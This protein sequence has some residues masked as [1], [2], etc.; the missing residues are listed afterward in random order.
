[1]SDLCLLA[2][3]LLNQGQLPGKSISPMPLSL[4]AAAIA[5]SPNCQP[6]L[7]KGTPPSAESTQPEFSRSSAAQSLTQSYSPLRLLPEITLPSPYPYPIPIAPE[8]S[9]RLLE[10]TPQV[11]QIA[12]QTQ[13]IRLPRPSSGSQLYQQRLA[14]LSA[15]RTYTRL[16]VDSFY[17]S[18]SNA[19]QQPTYEQW[20]GLLGQEA[21][22]IASGQ[23][24]NRLTV[25][26]GDS[27][28][29]WYPP[30]QLSS[31]RLWL[32]Q[33]I[34]GDTTA[35]ILRRLSAFSQTRP[36][37]IHIMAGINDLRQG[38]TDE[39]V[40]TNLRQIMRQLRQTHPRAQVIVHSILPTRLAA[41]PT[42]RI[43][44]LNQNI[45][46]IAHQ[47]NVNYLDLQPNFIG[48]D[49]ILRRELT[50]DGLHLSRN[51]YA[52]LQAALR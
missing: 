11:P 21:R 31:D 28:L 24:N 9:P 12:P 42:E 22:A 47:E 26:V 1:M 49:G 51:G 6:T 20:T 2:A 19:T 13:P 23:G 15:G 30:E 10:Q 48:T 27:L 46:A 16:P 4:G 39:A 8:R 3:S 40:L 18:W 41:L 33:G 45:E 32:N 50:T 52:V 36:D 5:F 25:L 43:Y 37:T 34:S 29:L 17:E 7:T 35:G 14:A 44:R 38:A